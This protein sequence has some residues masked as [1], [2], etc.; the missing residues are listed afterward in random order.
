M[1]SARANNN[2]NGFESGTDTENKNTSQL[3][4][5]FVYYAVEF[6]Q[7]SVAQVSLQLP[8]P[9]GSDFSL[10]TT[11]LKFHLYFNL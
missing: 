8:H 10:D 3:E 4:V 6:G 2:C 11:K 7:N 1:L 9:R 5:G